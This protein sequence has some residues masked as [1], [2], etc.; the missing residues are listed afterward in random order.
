MGISKPMLGNLSSL[1][2]IC[3]LLIKILIFAIINYNILI[4]NIMQNK[5]KCD[6][7]QLFVFYLRIYIFILIIR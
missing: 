1:V 3:Y 5:V 6:Y 2:F 4:F 7:L